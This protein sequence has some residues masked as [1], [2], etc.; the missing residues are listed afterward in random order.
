MAEISEEDTTVKE[1]VQE[2]PDRVPA[3]RRA[4]EAVLDL[5]IAM[6]L[7]SDKITPSERRRLSDEKQRR[8]DLKPSAVLGVIETREGATPAQL[9]AFFGVL[10]LKRMTAIAHPGNLSRRAH[11]MCTGRAPV[12]QLHGASANDLVRASDLM[13]ALPRGD[14]DA[15]VWDAVSYAKHRKVPIVVVDPFGGIRSEYE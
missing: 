11:G 10:E 13:V 9:T 1:D 5:H 15:Y 12:K 8:K 6:W 4:L 7:A 2:L 14:T 3:K